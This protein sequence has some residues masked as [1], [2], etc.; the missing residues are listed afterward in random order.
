M[1]ARVFGFQFFIFIFIG[2]NRSL[3]FAKILNFSCNPVEIIFNLF[4]LNADKSK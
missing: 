3:T 4:D 1:I 2:I